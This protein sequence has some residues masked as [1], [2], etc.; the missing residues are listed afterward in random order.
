MKIRHASELEKL[1]SGTHPIREDSPELLFMKAVCA[2]EEERAASFF[3]PLKLFGNVPPVVDTPYARYEGLDGIRRF[4]REF[5]STFHAESSFPVPCIQT[6]ANG[7]VALEVS[8]NFA[9]DGQINQIPM[10]R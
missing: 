1:F 3:A 8:V 6:I 7:R 2:G 5:N 4:V 9:V 10:F